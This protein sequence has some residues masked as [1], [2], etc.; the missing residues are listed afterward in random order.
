MIFGFDFDFKWILNN[1]SFEK[2]VALA[3][4]LY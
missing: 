4:A 3:R 1:V 2:V